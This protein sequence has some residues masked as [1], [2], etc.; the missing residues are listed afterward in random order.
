M[1]I[2]LRYAKR[3][4]AD[5]F[6]SRV[7]KLGIHIE[8]KKDVRFIYFFFSDCIIICFN[9]RYLKVSSTNILNFSLTID[10]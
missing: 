2:K 7:M 10:K 5:S 9:F 3:P 4:E 8:Y 1:G 6:P